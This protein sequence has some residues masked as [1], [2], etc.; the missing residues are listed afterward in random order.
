MLVMA[1]LIFAAASGGDA[2][3]VGL[4][5]MIFYGLMM[6]ITYTISLPLSAAANALI[7]MDRRFRTE[8]LAVDL[9]AEAERS[10]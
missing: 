4:V 9:L 5:T 8:A 6:L 7:Y 10:R 1:G 2:S 3:T